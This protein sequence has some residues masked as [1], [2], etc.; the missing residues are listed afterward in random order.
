MVHISVLA[1]AASPALAASK[2][3]TPEN[4]LAIG[5]RFPRLTCHLLPP[6]TP[7]MFYQRP[8][9]LSICIQ[10]AV[11]LPSVPVA[12]CQMKNTTGSPRASGLSVMSATA[13]KAAISGSIF[14]VPEACFVMEIA[15]P[16]GST[17]AL[18]T[19]QSISRWSA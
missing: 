13:L 3:I 18:P 4:K 9:C 1:M 17:R 6:D 16:R 5:W 19:D 12:A 2:S 7:R 14:A 15:L 11:D 8:I 10:G